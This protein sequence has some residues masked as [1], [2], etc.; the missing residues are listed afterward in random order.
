MR[1]RRWAWHGS[2]RGRS[3]EKALPVP[4]WLSTEIEPPMA[5]ASREPVTSPRPMDREP[6]R[7]PEST[8]TGSKMR[9]M[10]SGLMPMPVSRTMIRTRPSARGSAATVTVPPSRLNL[11]ALTRRLSRTWTSRRRSARTARPGSAPDGHS[12]CTPRSTACVRTRSIASRTASVTTIGSMA[13]VSRPE[14]TRVNSRTSSIIAS[15]WRPARR[16]CSRLSRSRSASV[17]SSSS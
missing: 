11:T 17:D 13:R 12:S 9:G 3:S 2:A 8:S 15:S 5:R 10:R 16:I 1:S 4:I 6:D 7:P 14:S